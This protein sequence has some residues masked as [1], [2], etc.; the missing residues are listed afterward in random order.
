MAIVNDRPYGAVP[1]TSA[2]S[3]RG[4]RT[5][6]I[7]LAG[8]AAVAVAAVVVISARAGSARP[9]AA[10]DNFPTTDLSILGVM[11]KMAAQDQ[12]AAPA[13]PVRT[14]T[15]ASAAPVRGEKKGLSMTEQY[16]RIMQ[17]EGYFAPWSRQNG[18]VDRVAI[19]NI[20]KA[21][22]PQALAQRQQMIETED[23]KFA[24]KFSTPHTSQYTGV[25]QSLADILDPKFQP[26]ANDAPRKA[27][28]AGF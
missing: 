26:W 17:N 23:K 15:M 21:N 6:F 12:A 13:A 20:R 25:H 10:L 7:G 28:Y 2:A 5:A 14:V 9:I 1:A 27:Y 8:L 24:K 4:K 18:W 16:A 3:H 19:D 11:Q 22:T